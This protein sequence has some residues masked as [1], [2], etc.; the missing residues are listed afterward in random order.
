MEHTHLVKGLDYALLQKARSEAVTFQ[1]QVSD[2][3]TSRYTLIQLEQE[4]EKP[5]KQEEEEEK[6]IET[7]YKT[8]SKEKK[9]EEEEI[10]LEGVKK[11]KK[12]LK[13]RRKNC[14]SSFSRN[15]CQKCSL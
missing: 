7:Y 8:I 5:V 15:C 13:F 11:N 3:V 10:F 14:N 9:E 4:D 1:D 2:E 6:E 12:I